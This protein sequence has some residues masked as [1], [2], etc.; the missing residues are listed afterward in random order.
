[1]NMCVSA[2]ARASCVSSRTLASV[3]ASG[4]VCFRLGLFVRPRACVRGGSWLCLFGL[5]GPRLR[6]APICS[7]EIWYVQA[8]APYAI[9]IVYIEIL[10]NSTSRAAWE[11][12]MSEEYGRPVAM[13]NAYGSAQ[14]SYSDPPFWGMSYTAG[15]NGSLVRSRLRT[16]MFV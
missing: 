10:P 8:F 2:H 15:S 12:L 14:R 16:C 3:C 7:G 1:M 9:A 5:C 13:R 6:A 4:H 11:A